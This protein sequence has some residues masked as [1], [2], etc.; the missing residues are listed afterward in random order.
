MYHRSCVGRGGELWY[1]TWDRC[2]WDPTEQ[3][4]YGGTFQPKTVRN[5]ILPHCRDKEHWSLDAIVMLGVMI[6]VDKDSGPDDP[7]KPFMFPSIHGNS[8]SYAATMVTTTIRKATDEI[9]ELD[10]QTSSHD[11]RYGVLSDMQLN[12]DLQII[13]AIFRGD[14]QFAGDSTGLSYCDR[15]PGTLEAGKAIAGWKC[16]KELIVSLD[17]DDIIF[18]LLGEDAD[19]STITRMRNLVES[20]FRR[21]PLSKEKTDQCYQLRNVF[22]VAVIE[23]APIIVADLQRARGEDAPADIL[24]STLRY[25]LVKHDFSWNDLLCWSEKVSPLVCL[26]KTYFNLINVLLFYDRS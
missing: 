12:K 14:W 26:T 5:G 13:Y 3:A 4:M 7:K 21:M 22:F 15:Q 8:S 16:T 17:L 2:F 19:A 6:V 23:M 1:C 10:P 20:L 9:E 18:E 24:E 25:E 11:I